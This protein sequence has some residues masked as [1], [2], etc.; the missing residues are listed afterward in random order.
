[1]RSRE[2]LVA[3]KWNDGSSERN[4]SRSVFQETDSLTLLWA[5]TSN[6]FSEEMT[7]KSL[8]NPRRRALNHNT[9][10][11]SKTKN[12]GNGRKLSR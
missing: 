8:M 1:M 2:I 4:V 9:G 7:S 12:T 11:P 6:A 10:Y 5:T 3:V